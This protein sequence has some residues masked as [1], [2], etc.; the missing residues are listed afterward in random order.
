MLDSSRQL[1][2]LDTAV[3]VGVR[4]YTRF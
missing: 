4:L 1:T 3:V 2:S